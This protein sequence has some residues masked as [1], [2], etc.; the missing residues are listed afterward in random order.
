MNPEVLVLAQLTAVNG[1]RLLCVGGCVR[2]EL[3]GITPS[4]YDLEVYGI[5]PDLLLD[6]LKR[7]YRVSTTGQAFGVIK[8]HDHPIDVSIPRRES[9]AG[10]GHKG[11]TILS[12][13]GMTPEE[14]ML[15]DLSYA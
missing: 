15:E 4:D 12:D 3:L 13:P 2:D 6:L 5:E 9:K 8:L 1:G 7:H 10:L 14:A 11:F